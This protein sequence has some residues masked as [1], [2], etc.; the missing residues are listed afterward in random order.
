MYAEAGF[1][2]DYMMK[3][4]LN[5]ILICSCSIALQAQ[6][7]YGI[8]KGYA[9]YKAVIH[10]AL[11][12]DDNGKPV[13]ATDTVRFLYLESKGNV[14]PCI[15]SV[16][17][18]NRLYGATVFS[19]GKKSVEAGIKRKGAQRVMIPC[20][21]GNSLWKV[22][23][24]FVAEQKI[25]KSSNTNKIIVKGKHAGRNISYTINTETELVADIVG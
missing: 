22:E 6:S 1:L 17:Y 4:F 10:G 7:P 14:A 25:Y 20:T 11:M 16:F 13:N 9:F 23:L 21:K 5:C 3:Y 18:G 15:D 19:A 2:V 24:I 12:I 8:Q